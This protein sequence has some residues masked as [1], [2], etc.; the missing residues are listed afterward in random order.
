VVAAQNAAK[1]AEERAERLEAELAKAREAPAGEPA[2][3]KPQ[4]KGKAK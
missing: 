1:E 2:E 4:P 3:E